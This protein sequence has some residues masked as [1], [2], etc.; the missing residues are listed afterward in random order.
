MDLFDD[1]DDVM[2]WLQPLDY[3]GFWKAVE[4]WAIFTDAD[5]THCDAVIADGVS[6]EETVLFGL[7]AMTRMALTERFGLK[8]R[9]YEPVTAQYLATTH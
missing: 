5:R 9:I 7:K 1:I 3:L 2:A 4:P 6:P 8:D